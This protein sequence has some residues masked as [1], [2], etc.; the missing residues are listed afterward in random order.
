MLKAVSSA[1]HVY[2]FNL[3]F[4]LLW[5]KLFWG[6]KQARK[7]VQFYTHL[8]GSNIELSGTYF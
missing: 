1:V 8:T 5:G 7:Y 3:N 4:L 6:Q 2:L